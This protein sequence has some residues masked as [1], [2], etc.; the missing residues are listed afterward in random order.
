MGKD[1]L[2]M[3]RKETRRFM[4]VFSSASFLNDLGSDMIYPIWP[5]FTI[6]VL[7]ANMAI[8][9]LIDGLGDAIVSI[10]QAGSGYLSDR[11]RKRKVFIWSGYLCGSASRVGYALSTAWQ[12][13]FPF[14]IL[15]RAGKIRGAPRDAIVADISTRENRGRNFGLLR[16]MDHMGGACG[17]IVSILFLSYLGYKRLFLLASIPSLIGALLIF[18]FI[19]DRKTHEIYK[20][21]SFKDLTSNLKLF[22]ILSSLFALGSFSYSFLLLYAREFGF[23]ETV[24][25]ALYLIFTVTAFL[26]SLPFG[27]LADKLGRKIVL[28]LSYSLWGV[29]CLG[30]VLTRSYMGVVLLFVLYG[31]HLGA[32]QP[33]QRT[34]VSE[35]S[36]AEY[37]A[38]VLGAFQMIVG[39]CALPASVVAGLLWFNF[40]MYAPFYFSLGLTTLS[41]ALML[42]VKE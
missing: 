20:G 32:I 17:V 25:L 11:L 14:R 3:N 6:E 4:A 38:S 9:G 31:L 21:L 24:V 10:S 5:L 12:H 16:A 41:V 19:K 27:K 29:L 1:K 42:F 15:D 34:L 40:G 39:L 33:V 28:I 36:P 37:R 35:L 26:M 30:F 8:L 22:L 23:E 13:L 7:G 2:N 18:L